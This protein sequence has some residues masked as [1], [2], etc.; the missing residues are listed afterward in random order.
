MQ[1]QALRHRTLD[2]DIAHTNST[3]ALVLIFYTFIISFYT[4]NISNL[5]ILYPC[6]WPHGWPKHVGVH[7]TYKTNFSMLACICWYH[8]RTYS[9]N[10]RV[11][12][13]M[14]PTTFLSSFPIYLTEF[15]FFRN[16]KHLKLTV[17][18]WHTTLKPRNQVVWTVAM[19]R[20]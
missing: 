18:S 9:I 19:T 20:L 6:R 7:C 15:N 14:K 16:Y 2:R 17:V 10:A 3:F 8:H 1:A 5:C 4:F 13:H 11:M 12:N